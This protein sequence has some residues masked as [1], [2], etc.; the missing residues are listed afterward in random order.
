MI[1]W[2]FALISLTAAAIAAFVP[3]IRRATLAL[4]VAGLAVGGI[5]L[6]IGAETLA[7]VQW[8]V[9]TL[10]SISLG[11]FSAM[12]GEY[13]SSEKK[14]P[15]LVTRLGS[16]FLALAILAGGALAV[17]AWKSAMLL[18]SPPGAPASG[19]ANDLMALG[20]ALV[21]RNA[22]SLQ[23][24]ALTLFLVLVG[25]GVIARPEGAE[26]RNAAEGGSKS[27]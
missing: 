16:G 3:D 24:L 1:E 27:E 18:P 4:W 22:I 15:M 13:G 10:V 6:T 21:E 19:A 2:S 5:F 9:S 14:R 17:I 23:V 11:F 26:P 7:I 12:F 20:K 8:I 25:G